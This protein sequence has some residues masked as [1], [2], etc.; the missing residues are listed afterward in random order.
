MKISAST[1]RIIAEHASGIR[2]FDIKGI[3]LKLGIIKDD[4]E[5]YQLLEEFKDPVSDSKEAKIEAILRKLEGQPELSTFITELIVANKLE[6]ECVEV[7]DRSLSRDGLY[8]DRESNTLKPNVGH[9]DEEEYITSKL[10]DSLSNLDPKFCVV[11]KGIWDAISSGGSDAYRGAI[12]SCRELLRQVIDNLASSGDTRRSKLHNILDSTTRARLCDSVA[13]FI[14]KLYDLLSSQEHTD[15][16]Y[17][18]VILGVKLTEHLL[19][20]LMSY[21]HT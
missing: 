14:D 12:A 2:E 8:F 19:Y 17:E 21:V 18:D 7:I 1:R 13:N 5:Y 6:N 16:S 3:I 9:T 11:H 20:Y 10:D 4:Q 15:P